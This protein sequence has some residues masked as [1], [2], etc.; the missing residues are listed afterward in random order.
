MNMKSNIQPSS[1]RPV[2]LIGLFGLIYAILTAFVQNTYYQL[3]M[4]VVPIWAVMGLSWNILSGY[5]GY[6]SFGHAA[7]FGLGAYFVA[8]AQIKLGMTPWISIPI[9][10]L[11]GGLAG[12]L[13][14]IPTFRLRGHYFA[15]AMLAY[16]LAFLYFFEWL[17]YQ[18]LALP[19]MRDDP[20]KYMQFEDTRIYAY[21]ALALMLGAMLLSNHIERSRFGLSLM[22]IKQDEAA[23]EAAGINTL[24]WKLK[25]ITLS[26]MLAG[27]IGGLYAVVLLIVTPPAVFGMLVSAQALILAMFGG[28]ASLWGPVIGAVALVPLS[29]FL[30]ARLGDLIPGIQGVVYGLAIV[31]VIL[32]APEGVFWKVKDL[33]R[34]REKKSIPVPKQDE[35]TE[36]SMNGQT[37]D[38]QLARLNRPAVSDVVVLE[39]RDVSKA[40]GG[41]KAVQ[42]VS[43]KVMQGEVLGII[44]PNGAGKT[45]FFNLLNGFIRPDSG[46][47][48]LNQQNIV[49]KLPFQNCIAGI[50]RTFQVVRPFRR[51]SIAQNVIVGAYVNA[52]TDAL[53]EQAAIEAMEQVGLLDQSDRLAGELSNKDL[54]LLELARALAGK[55]QILLL[56]ETLAGLG[57]SEVE[58]MITVIRKLASQGMTIAIIEH[59]MQA[60]VRLVDRFVVLDHGAVLAEGSPDSITKNHAVID[61]YLGKKWRASNA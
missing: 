27:A 43:L 4:A 57:S 29:E 32:L 36:Q 6:V 13:V 22:A 38:A 61:A 42:H 41:L 20:I 45:T 1:M 53:A 11:I 10:G 18:E 47:I 49:G 26:G 52:K 7:F 44:G 51:M 54:R 28:V 9:A 31:I 23:A 3:I 24:A 37:P 12:L 34:R 50:G 46:E 16:P 14:G 35:S 60:M 39:A 48:L 5:S 30:H 25:A 59:T 40:F 2:V 33:L 55:P 8:L 19:M 21:I 58:E 17:G 15:L 56:D